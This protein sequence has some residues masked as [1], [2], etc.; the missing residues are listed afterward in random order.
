MSLFLR[1][2]SQEDYEVI[3]SWI[4]TA[5]DCQRWAGRTMPF[6]F[7]PGD[8]G[9]LIAHA[10][11]IVAGETHTGY[12]IFQALG[13]ALGYGELVREDETTF[14]LARIIVAPASRRGGLG[15]ALC[16]Q[17]I[18]QAE[19]SPEARRV[20]LFAYRDNSSAIRL[21]SRLGFAEAPADARPEILAM[22]KR[23]RQE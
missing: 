8:L 4:R 14:R 1:A 7:L 10:P 12:V 21:Y 18:A 2:V 19:A 17:L 15:A 23:L 13:V 11:E 3:A 16:R 6:P 22:E 9:A 5:E 20:R